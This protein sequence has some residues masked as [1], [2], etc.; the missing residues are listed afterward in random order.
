MS[1]CNP[2]REVYEENAPPAPPPSRFDALVAEVEVLRAA[3]QALWE[4][5]W[6]HGLVSTRTPPRLR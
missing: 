1:A 2:I 4:S 5:A 6:Q 3:F